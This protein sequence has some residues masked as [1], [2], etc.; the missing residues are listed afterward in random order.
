MKVLLLL[1]FA[2]GGCSSAQR[3][4]LTD[5]GWSTSRPEAEGLDP[6]LLAE[7]VRFIDRDPYGDFRSL[8]V[9]RNGRIVAER[10]FNDHGPDS[11]L[12]VRSVTKSLTSA[13]VGIAVS[14]GIVPGIETRVLS[15]FPSYL[16]VTHDGEGKRGITLEHLL[17]MTSGLDA[18]ADD[19]RTPGHEDRLWESADWVRF[20]L[21]LPM[22]HAP[23][24]A[25]SYASVNT[26]L[27]GAAVEQ[28]A[29]QT[30]AEYAE[31]RLFGP[32]GISRYRWAETPSGRTV[33]QGNLSIRARDMAKLG[34]L[35][36]DGGRWGGRQVVPESWIRSSME[37]RFR[38]PWKGYDRYGYGWYTHELQVGGRQFRYVFASGNGGNKIYVFPEEEMVVVIQS[39]AYNTDYGQSRSFAVLEGVLAAVVA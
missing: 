22:E 24:E 9:T 21:D 3:E 34:Q 1:L 4:A 23:G 35:Y 10:Y 17:A 37:G 20:A 30:L 7:T 39:A 8:L 6:A 31:G 11:L 32:L 28:A 25:W 29:G 15:L 16:P 5:D 2:A 18:D 14:E 26:F 27:V 12:D 19:P 38:V 13:L 36:L 33:G